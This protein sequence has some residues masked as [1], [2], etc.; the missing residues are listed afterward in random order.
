[1][2]KCVGYI[3]KAGTF[4][5]NFGKSIDYDNTILYLE[6]DE[7]DNVVGLESTEL[8]LKTESLTNLCPGIYSANDL[9]GQVISLVY[10]FVSKYPVLKSIS[11]VPSK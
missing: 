11:I 2:I 1:M 6:S 9:V 7:N 8:K 5:D 10:S 4:K 3:R